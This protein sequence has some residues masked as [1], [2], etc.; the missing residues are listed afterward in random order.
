M[1]DAT[2]YADFTTAQLNALIEYLADDYEIAANETDDRAAHRRHVAKTSIHAVALELNARRDAH[3][4]ALAEHI[5]G[6]MPTHAQIMAF[7]AAHQPH[8]R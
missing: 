1:R 5:G 4:E 3:A 2:E 8:Q 7:H 6:I